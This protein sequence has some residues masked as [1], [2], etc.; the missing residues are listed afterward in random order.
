MLSK[1]EKKL[2]LQAEIAYL[3]YVK[4][5]SQQ[6]I[7]SDIGLNRSQISRLITEA[8]TNNIVTI[9]VSYPFRVTSIE[10]KLLK[11]FPQ[12]DDV[13]VISYR[14]EESK[15]FLNNL[16]LF[17]ARYIAGVLDSRSKIAVGWGKTL[18][19]VVQEMPQLSFPKALV[20]QAIGATGFYGMLEDGP[21]IARKLSEKLNCECQ[22]LHYPLIV[23]SKQIRDSLLNDIVIKDAFEQV[24]RSDILIT[25]IGTVLEDH[26]YTLKEV[27]YVS[28]E[29]VKKIRDSGAVG[30]IFGMHFD[31]NGNV[32]DIDINSRTISFPLE[33]FKEIRKTIGIAGHVGKAKALIGAVRGRHINTLITDYHAAMA[34]LKIMK[35]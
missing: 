29:E 2:A 11:L 9:A 33:K 1:E 8:K 34:M 12:L 16:G 26:L 27:G 18:H 5:K 4:N 20:V 19:H 13:C 24:S 28:D 32:L 22:L 35:Q 30:D 31:I 10:E 21:M 7:A 23:S 6:E 14:E 25:G 15:N 3:Y 17:A